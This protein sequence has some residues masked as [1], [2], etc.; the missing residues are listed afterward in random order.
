MNKL[1]FIVIFFILVNYITA[2]DNCEIKPILSEELNSINKCAINKPIK[3][4]E[5]LKINSQ[6]PKKRFL[7]IRKKTAS[8]SLFK[9]IRSKGIEKANTDATIITESLIALKKE[10]KSILNFSDVDEIPTFKACEQANSI[11]E[12]GICFNS[13][14]MNFLNREI[15]DSDELYEE[16]FSGDISVKFVI[17]TDGKTN[18]IQAKG[19]KKARIAKEV[20]I[21]IISKLPKLKPAIKDN[22]KVVVQY[23]FSLKFSD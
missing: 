5:K 10:H 11:Q 14:M 7:T 4:G 1:Q 19:H 15:E 20:I 2:Q 6:I 23:E 18:N 12:K 16:D 22:K 8:Y 21:D 17:D 13:K 9:N 3:T